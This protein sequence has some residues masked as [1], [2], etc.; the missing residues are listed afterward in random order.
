M[1]I[2]SSDTSTGLRTIATVL[3]GFAAARV[4]G[5]VADGVDHDPQF[6]AHQHGERGSES[7]TATTTTHDPPTTYHLPPTTYHLPPTTTYHP[8]PTTHLPLHHKACSSLRPW[9]RPLRWPCYYLVL[10]P[11]PA[12]ALRLLERRNEDATCL[13][14][15]PAVR[16]RRRCRR[17]NPTSTVCYTTTAP[18][19]K[20]RTTGGFGRDLV[21]GVQDSG[22]KLL[23]TVT[24]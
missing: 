9:E 5:Y 18:L 22:F 4:Y 23:S 24:K 13:L 20:R 10:I 8:P 15:L 3:G 6:R 1:A 19:F 7:H 2:L 21:T 12:L 16:C 17:V 11:R 14:D